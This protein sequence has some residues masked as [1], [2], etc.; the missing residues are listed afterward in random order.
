MENIEKLLEMLP[1]RY[2]E[3]AME[4][5]TLKRRREI[6][7][8]FDLLMLVF[9][10]VAQRLSHFEVSV[11]AKMKRIAQISDVAFMKRFA[12][13]RKLIEWLLENLASQATA[14]YS[15]PSKSK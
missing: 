12:K 8:A 1:D 6:K 7:T 4:T 3:A 13:C 9:Q 15:K 10:Y 5:D 14:H 2:E 11:Y